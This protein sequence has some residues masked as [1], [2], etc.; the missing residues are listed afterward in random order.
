MRD[1]PVL[2]AGYRLRVVDPPCPKMREGD[3]KGGALVPVTDRRTGVTYFVVSVF[4][5]LQVQAGERA[6][7]G[8]ELKVTLET[9]PGEGFDEG[10]EVELL[11]PRVSAYEIKTE[12]ERV[13][14]GL[15]Y[16]A[17]GLKAVVRAGVDR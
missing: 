10:A 11:N 12:D 14:S 4:A 16:K 3:K 1:L 17:L 9:D 15:S 8:E 7:K 5:K 6:P 13:I 2:L